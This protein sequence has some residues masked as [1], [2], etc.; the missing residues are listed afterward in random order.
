MTQELTPLERAFG[1][2][3]QE[4]GSIWSAVH[5]ATA[6]RPGS[7]VAFVGPDLGVGVTCIA[8]VAA[9]EL[10]RNFGRRV[11]LVETDVESPRLAN[12]LGIPAS[13]GLREI[14]EGQA[15]VESATR[16]KNLPESLSVVVAGAA[17]DS[18][19]GE[20]A[21]PTCRELM[22]GLREGHDLTIL[23]TPPVLSRLDARVVLEYADSAVL[24]L[25]ARETR[26]ESATKTLTALQDAGVEVLGTVLNR[27]R[28]DFP[29]FG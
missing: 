12:Y 25:R 22:D 18:I 7:R 9:L 17:R 21:S 23:D 27:F 1:R 26:T 14:L 20:L 10:A 3:I 8:A 24:V 11:C 6:D 28:P 19:P 5:R 2:S 4:T 13:P 15:D 16:R 29:S